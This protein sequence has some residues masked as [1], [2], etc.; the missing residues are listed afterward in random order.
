MGFNIIRVAIR[1]K[2][3][4]SQEVEN[5][6]WRCKESS[7]L[8]QFENVHLNQDCFIIGNGP[9]LNKIGIE[10]LNDYYTFGLNKIFLIQQK[11]DLSFHYYVAVNRL[12]VE[13]SINEINKITCPKFIS[14]TAG[15]DFFK[16]DKNSYFVKSGRG[17]FFQKDITQPLSE[18]HTVTYVALQ[19]AY[20]MGFKN[21]YLVGVDHSFKQVGQPNSVEKLENDDPNHFS[22]DYFRGMNWNLADLFNSEISYFLAKKY[23]F[24]DN[25]N[26]FDATTGGKLDIFPKI[27]FEEALQKAKKKSA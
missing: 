2:R 3:Q 13:Q 26:V 6:W 12:V 18:G 8:R 11:I 23:Y 25:R 21:V 16:G 19:I 24:E 20:F 14:Y 17:T 9:S 7:K 15:K 10:K 4:F 27:S 22:P 5:E 1:T